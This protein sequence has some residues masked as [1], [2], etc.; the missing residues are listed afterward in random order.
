MVETLSNLPQGVLGFRASGTVTTDDLNR[1]TEPIYATLGHHEPLDLYVEI[2]DDFEG[3]DSDAR[4]QGRQAAMSVGLRHSSSVRRLALVTDNGW[5]RTY[6]NAY[7]WLV[8]GE[9]R[10]FEPGMRGEAR[11]WLTQRVAA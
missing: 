2:A 3:L 5:V 10:V 1:F 4:R 6:L 9:V 7:S 11:S 8:P